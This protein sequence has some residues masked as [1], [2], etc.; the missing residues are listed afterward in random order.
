MCGTL[1]RNLQQ[2][3][4]YDITLH[5]SKYTYYNVPRSHIGNSHT[6]FVNTI[7]MISYFYATTE[8]EKANTGRCKGAVAFAN[9]G[10]NTPPAGSRHIRRPAPGKGGMPEH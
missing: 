3:T 1:A 5:V 7:S 4:I 9:R 2:Y 10:R 6:F 8:E